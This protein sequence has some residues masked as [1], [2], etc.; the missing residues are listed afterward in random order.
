MPVFVAPR[1]NVALLSY[2]LPSHRATVVYQNDRAAADAADAAEGHAFMKMPM[3]ETL[4][5]QQTV[6]GFQ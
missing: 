1:F 6:T 4:S 2:L 5:G 3:S